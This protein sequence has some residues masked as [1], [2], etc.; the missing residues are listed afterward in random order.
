MN[1]PAANRANNKLAAGT[2][3]RRQYENIDGTKSSADNNNND[4]VAF[5]D[6]DNGWT[7]IGYRRNATPSAQNGGTPG[8][9]HD[10]KQTD[11]DAAREAVMISEIMYAHTDRTTL[12]WIELRNTSHTIGVDLSLWELVIVN[13]HEMMTVDDMGVEN[14]G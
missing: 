9:P 7:G 1:F 3:Q 10:A 8:Y 11:S 12:Q 4:K 2:V 14:D 6:D 13:H 5:R